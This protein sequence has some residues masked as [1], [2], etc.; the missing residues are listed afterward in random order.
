MFAHDKIQPV[1]LPSVLN[2][3][4]DHVLNDP[5]L[6]RVR[7]N[8]TNILLLDS[9]DRN[10]TLSPSGYNYYIH[11]I[12]QLDYSKRLRIH[13]YTLL[14]TIPTINKLNNKIFIN[15]DGTTKEIILD[16]G[17][18]DN[19]K[20]FGPGSLIDHVVTRI[21]SEI[22]TDT[23]VPTQQAGNPQNYILT[24]T[25]N[26]YFLPSLFTDN[27]PYLLGIPTDDTP[28]MQKLIT[29]NFM[30][31]FKYLEIRSPLLSQHSRLKAHGTNNNINNVIGI[32]SPTA[33]DYSKQSI[34]TGTFEQPYININIGSRDLS[35]VDIYLSTPNNKNLGQIEQSNNGSLCIEFT[36]EA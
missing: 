5:Q 22:T 3:E 7:T 21:N 11:N 32:I 25:K 4:Q 35:D 28:A 30:L 29:N 19:T 10:K 20:L 2:Y 36:T 27:S 15:S 17:F 23:L 6:I 9:D 26:F 24:G 18:Y 8:I 1:V 16:I 12:L 34:I 31:P 33:D 13:K 14:W